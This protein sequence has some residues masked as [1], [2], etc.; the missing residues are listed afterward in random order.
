MQKIGMAFRP[1]PQQRSFIVNRPSPIMRIKAP[2]RKSSIRTSIPRSRPVPMSTKKPVRRGGCSS[3]G[4][5]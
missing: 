3:C 2:M 1:P 4:R 5:R